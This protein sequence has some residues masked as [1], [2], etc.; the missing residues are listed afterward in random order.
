M[1]Y[2]MIVR[3][4]PTWFQSTPLVVEG[5]CLRGEFDARALQQRFQSTPLVVEGRCAARCPRHP[6][7]SVVDCF[8]PRPSLSRGDASSTTMAPASSVSIHAPRRSTSG[9]NPRPSLSRGDACHGFNADHHLFNERPAIRKHKKFQS[10]PLV[11]EGRC[12]CAARQ[13]AGRNNR[14]FQS[15]PLVVEGRCLRIP[16][17]PIF[18]VPRFQ[19]TPLV[20]EGRCRDHTSPQLAESVEHSCFNPR[21]SLSR[22]DAGKPVPERAYCKVSIHAP[23][24]RG[25]MQKGARA[26]TAHRCFN[27]RP[28]LSRGDAK[29]V[30]VGIETAGEMMFQST[31]LVVEGRCA[32]EHGQFGDKRCFN[33]RPSLSRGDAQGVPFR[34]RSDKSVSI[35]APRCRGAMR[36]AGNP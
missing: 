26:A 31:P 8:N 20:V 22:G 14:L 2:D 11:V 6:L 15:T 12:N 5:R 17:L 36:F 30:L 13:A 16:A 33:P 3:K 9:F 32:L 28:S 35:H 1:H 25:A 19:S 23:R 24:C 21:P 18:L 29:E 7:P 4:L 27:P 10:T 34:L